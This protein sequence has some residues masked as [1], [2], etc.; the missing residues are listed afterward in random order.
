MAN[1]KNRMPR[2]AETARDL[3][4]PG[5]LTSL[6][7]SFPD[8]QAYEEMAWPSGLAVQVCCTGHVCCHCLLL[9]NPNSH[10]CC[11]SV[12]A[13]RVV[14]ALEFQC[15]TSNM[16]SLHTAHIQMCSRLE[17]PLKREVRTK[18][19]QQTAFMSAWMWLCHKWRT[20]SDG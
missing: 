10:G 3:T 6:Q 2:N 17:K 9:R 5:G 8:D 20:L 15:T 18:V 1:P 4:Q 19:K 11:V 13:W 7:V 16:K 12:I 14:F